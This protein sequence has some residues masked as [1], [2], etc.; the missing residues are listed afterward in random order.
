M[1]IGYRRVMYRQRSRFAAE[2][3]RGLYNT[4]HTGRCWGACSFLIPDVSM[5]KRRG[6]LVEHV[7]RASHALQD[8]TDMYLLLYVFALRSKILRKGCEIQMSDVLRH[9]KVAKLGTL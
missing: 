6:T 5:R 2:G 4:G 9:I 7:T 3:N 1:P 8:P